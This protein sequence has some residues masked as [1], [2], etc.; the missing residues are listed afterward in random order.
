MLVYMDGDYGFSMRALRYGKTSSRPER[1]RGYEEAKGVEILGEGK[2]VKL[3]WCCI[4]RYMAY[5]PKL[6]IV[7]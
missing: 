5:L 4:N 3:E 7:M 6:L 2:D 1:L